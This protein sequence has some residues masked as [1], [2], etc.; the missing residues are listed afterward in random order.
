MIIIKFEDFIKNVDNF[1]YTYSLYA[2]NLPIGLNDEVLLEEELYDVKDNIDAFDYIIG[3][4]DIKG[5]LNNL[6]IQ[7]PN[8]MDL[9]IC[10]DAVNYYIEYDAFIDLEQKK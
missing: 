6:N 1:N 9:N 10:V 4:E 7:L 2:K 3:I 5:V 8:N